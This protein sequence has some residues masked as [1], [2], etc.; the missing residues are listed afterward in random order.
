MNI[1]VGST[2]KADV[3]YS[4]FTEGA[5]KGI[6]Y[7][8]A[9]VVKIEKD[10]DKVATN[11]TVILSPADTMASGY[12]LYN[13]TKN[14]GC[15]AKTFDA[16]NGATTQ[17]EAIRVTN[18]PSKYIERI[19]EVTFSMWVR[20]EPTMGTPETYY[21][22]ILRLFGLD[23]YIDC[24][25]NFRIKDKNSN[26]QLNKSTYVMPPFDEVTWFNK[27]LHIALT[28]DGESFYFFINGKKRATIKAQ[29]YTNDP[30]NYE[31]EHVFRKEPDTYSRV[32]FNDAILMFGVCLWKD[33]FS[34][35]KDFIFN[36][37]TIVDNFDKYLPKP[38]TLDF[39]FDTERH[40]RK[41][42][43]TL[44][45]TE[46]IVIGV[47]TTYFD[48]RLITAK[49]KSALFD[50]KKIVAKNMDPY[51]DTQRIVI[52][53]VTVVQDTVRII[54]SPPGNM[55]VDIPFPYRQFTDT[56]FFLTE[57][58]DG[59]RK[60]IPDDQYKRIGEYQIWIMT[61]ASLGLTTDSEIRFTFCHNKNRYHIS[62]VEYHMFCEYN[63][64][65]EYDIPGSPYNYNMNLNQRFHVWYNRK[66][67]TQTKQFNMDSKYGK[68]YIQDTWA[69]PQ[70][71]DRIDIVVFYTG[72]KIDYRINHALQKLPMSGYIYLK[73]HMIDRNY[74]NNLMAVFVNGELIP[75]DKIIEMSNNV[76]KIKEDIHMRHN[77]EVRN[78]SPRITSL[79]PFYK[80]ACYQ[81]ETPKQY[82][83]HDLAS[84]ICV[85]H[86]EPQGRKQVDGL[87]NPI[88]FD[89]TVLDNPELWIS[90]IHRGKDHGGEHFS[91]LDYNL[92]FY[93]NDYRGD[94]E[95]TPIQIIVELREK[96]NEGEKEAQS[97]TSILLGEIPATLTEINNDYCFASTQIKKILEIDKYNRS[98]YP[99]QYGNINRALDGIVGR[100]Q[101]PLNRKYKSRP[102]IYYKLQSNMFTVEDKVGIL[103]WVISTGRD[104]TGQRLWIKHIDFE[105]SHH[106]TSIY[107]ENV[108][109]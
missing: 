77:V 75:R 97:Y 29:V 104:G 71:G 44:F 5:S 73:R 23:V 94:N 70:V 82:W 52:G 11:K 89:P 56:E 3:I 4:E 22:H 58:N 21:Y 47:Y 36:E 88:Y 17:C 50:T 63:G 84:T 53:N 15:L 10:T 93:E 49:E 91:A 106:I 99:D 83:Y 31:V 64:Q 26:N 67:V 62:K 20:V 34:T 14:N 41:V 100:L 40:I 28:G 24:F 108:E 1:P 43:E 72:V 35:P 87:L 80:K 107:D 32:L 61:P 102:I 98:R 65:L 60:L 74:D 81:L 46:R 68:L 37:Y 76:Y 45:D 78:M 86:P 18:I 12:P 42:I 55:V 48:T 101:V 103:E 8:E 39:L 95:T 69:T 57:S 19:P 13:A 7:D 96:A 27:W 92:S 6:I 79:V 33:D 38:K 2:I 51:F 25:D 109:E 30:I 66:E 59:T 16:N 90:L 85:G 105:P 9:P 54:T